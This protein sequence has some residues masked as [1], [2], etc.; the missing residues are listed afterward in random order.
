MTA[1]QS[2]YTFADLFSPPDG[3]LYELIRGQLVEKKMGALSIWIAWQ[4]SHL[5]GSYLDRDP[6]GWVSTE[7]PVDCFRWIASHARRPDVVYFQHDRLAAP[8]QE[9]IRVAPNWV[10][11]VLSPH[12][13]ALEVDEK[14]E[15]YLRAGVDL[16]WIVNPQTRTVRV[17]HING[18][19][20]L[21]HE[22]DT[23]TADP[24]LPGFSS[25]VSDFFPKPL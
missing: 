18:G 6:R 12:D 14:I 9:P 23:I 16:V 20:S 25:P 19:I 4:I 22:S 8:T 13:N 7:L 1:V 11:E 21:F 15:E 3:K 17:H 2:E 5:I 24:V 10:V